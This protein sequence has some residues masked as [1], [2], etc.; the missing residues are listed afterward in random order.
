MGCCDITGL[1]WGQVEALEW[2]ALR[3]QDLCRDSV[4]RGMGFCEITCFMW[5]LFEALEWAAVR[6]QDLCG[7]GVRRCNGLL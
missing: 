7:E 4:R 5:G 1:M 6:L 3:L 2:A